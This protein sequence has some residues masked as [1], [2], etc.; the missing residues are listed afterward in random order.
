MVNIYLILFY[1]W[2]SWAFW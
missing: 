2:K 1:I